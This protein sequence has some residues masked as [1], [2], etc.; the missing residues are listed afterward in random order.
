MSIKLSPIALLVFSAALA[1]LSCSEPQPFNSPFHD[2]KAAP[3][4]RVNDLIRLMRPEEKLALLRE[5]SSMSIK[6][7]DRLG[8]HALAVVSGPM[9]ISAKDASGRPIDATA[10][11]A[12]IAIA[13]TW[14]PSLSEQ[15]GA[16]IAQEARALG[17]GQV[18]GPLAEIA[19]SPL[20][21]S[22]F[23]SYGEDPYLASGI[24]SGYIAGVQGES[25]IATA[26]YK[27]GAAGERLSRE[28]ELRP[29]EA[30]V[31]NAGVWSVMPNPGDPD[32][33]ILR[34]LLED[35]LGFRGFAV[36][37]K[38]HDDYAGLPADVTDRRVRAVLRAMFA[39]GAF[40]LGTQAK[41]GID[42]AAQR[43]V[44]RDAAV[45]SIVLLKNEKA[46]LPLKSTELR[47][48]AVFG[49]TAATIR[50]GGGNYTVVTKRYVTPLQSLTKLFGS[51]I[52]DGSGITSAAD[53][54]GLARGAD[55][56]IVF[57]GTGAH[58]E[59]EGV[60]RASLDLPAGQDELI[61]AVAKANPHTIV[62]LTAGSPVSMARWIKDVPAVLDAWFPGEEGGNAIADILTGAADPSGR[63]P[64]TFLDLFPFG[65]GLSYT[66]F[67]YSNLVVLPQVTHP[68]QF[69]EVSLDV[70]NTG[71]RTGRE[72]V[73]LYLH[74]VTSKIERADQNLKAFGQVDLD[75]G[76]SK[77]VRFILNASATSYFDEKRQDWAQDQAIFEVSGRIVIA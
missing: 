5:A 38:P 33:S 62:V 41:G 4:R 71:A 16:V 18:L 22:V 51:R 45:R 21:G 19:R 76:E 23:E 68:G 44:A 52:R 36:F 26:L 31:S 17:R 42:T 2:P 48:V 49:P 20:G 74:P 28:R 24:L 47:S 30:A 8:I 1:C 14:S 43:A 7:N 77:R 3:E 72:T 13:A 53:A 64:M 66:R 40:D 67:E 27:G 73:Q 70:R 56:A 54:A 57:A 29:L 11:P 10:F 58:T 35:R 25:E 55:V 46:T 12:N 39:S 32:G 59:I 61:E 50:M 15:E 34:G 65:F 6:G 69:V 75:P 60:D 37:S 63:L 9:G